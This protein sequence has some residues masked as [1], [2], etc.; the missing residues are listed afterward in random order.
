MKMHPFPRVYCDV[1][2]QFPSSDNLNPLAATSMNELNAEG[3]NNAAGTSL[4]S[5]SD[6]NANSFFMTHRHV[7]VEELDDNTLVFID[8]AGT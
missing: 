1:F 5:R 2:A 4:E 6:I 8:K 3:V 7:P